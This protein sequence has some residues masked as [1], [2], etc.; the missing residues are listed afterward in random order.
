VIKTPKTPYEHTCVVGPFQC[1]CRLVVCPETS[2]SI[3][4]DP[5]DEAEKILKMI[6]QASQSVQAQGRPPIEVRGLF[7]THAHLDHIGATK[8]VKLKLGASPEAAPKI[9]LHKNDLKLYEMLSTQSQLFGLNYGDPSPVDEW[10]EDDQLL[11]VGTL[12]F[13]IL[14]TPGHSPGSVSIQLEQQEGSHHEAVF[15]GDT[16]FQGSIGRTDLWEGNHELLI[17]SIKQRLFTLNDDIRVGPG[18]GEDSLIGIEK[19]ENPFFQ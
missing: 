6:K 9:Y 3:L 14:H 19:R 16:L 2:K 7:H 13:K 15:T 5:G 4:I 17:K 10:F 1:N 18:H 11:K 12:R 8:E